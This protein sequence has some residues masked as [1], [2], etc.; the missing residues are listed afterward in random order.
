[1]LSAIPKHKGT[2]KMQADIKS[3][4]AKLKVDVKK[5][6][7]KARRRDSSHVK[8]EGAGQVVLVGAPNSGKSALDRLRR[9]DFDRLGII[10]VCTKAPGKPADTDRPF[11]LPI[12]ATVVDLAR[13]IHKDLVFN[14][15][16]ACIWG[17]GKYDGQRVPLNH[18]LKDMDILEIHS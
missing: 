6:K 2:E 10:R 1:M 8:R 3:K 17:A 15:K 18:E 9:H 12:G 4:I 16:F 13:H 11:V 7:G 14:M 5:G